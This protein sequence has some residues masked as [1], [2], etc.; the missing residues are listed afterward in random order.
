MQSCVLPAGRSGGGPDQ[1]GSVRSSWERV[2]GDT[3]PTVREG[4]PSALS[5]RLDPQWGQARERDLSPLGLS[6]NFPAQG[7]D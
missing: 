7:Q 1:G 3:A 5:S 2:G 6:S 4:G